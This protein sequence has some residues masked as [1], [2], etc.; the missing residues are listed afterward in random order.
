MAITVVGRVL[1]VLTIAATDVAE[2][3]SLCK[4]CNACTLKASKTMRLCSCGASEVSVRLSDLVRASWFMS[5]KP[6]QAP[7]LISGL[8]LKNYSDTLK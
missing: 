6:N 3:Y 4:C 1:L 5:C 2:S 7:L 8:G